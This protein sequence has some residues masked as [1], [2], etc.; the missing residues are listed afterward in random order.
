M[1]D[2][3]DTTGVPARTIL[4]T[5]AT[6]AAA[7]RCDACGNCRPDALDAYERDMVR[8][9]LSGIAPRGRTVGAP[10]RPMLLGRG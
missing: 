10:H 6:P 1:I 5:S 8:K 4:G 3:A 2:Y 7:K 9:M